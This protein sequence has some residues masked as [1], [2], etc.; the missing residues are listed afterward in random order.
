MPVFVGAAE[1]IAVTIEMAHCLISS[2]RTESNRLYRTDYERRSF[3][4]GAAIMVSQRASELVAEEK[5]SCAGSTGTSLTLV[6]NQLERANEEWMGKKNLGT[7]KSRAVYYDLEAY[8]DGTAYGGQVQLRKDAKKLW[9]L[10]TT[11]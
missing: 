2:I 3:R 10:I 7:F 6:R 1:N 4:L 5:Q 9:R 8:E 11:A